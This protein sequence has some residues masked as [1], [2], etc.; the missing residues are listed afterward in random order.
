MQQK[1]KEEVA[2]QKLEEEFQSW[3]SHPVTSRLRRVLQLWREEYRD[4]WEEGEHT[5]PTEIGNAIANAKAIGM[6]QA[7]KK[8]LELD[9]NAIEK[10]LSDEEHVGTKSTRPGGLG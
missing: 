9:A 5:H 4:R 10:E 6:C 8:I 7:F 2:Q 1:T 3:I